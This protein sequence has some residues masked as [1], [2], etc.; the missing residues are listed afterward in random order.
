MQQSLSFAFGTQNVTSTHHQASCLHSC[1]RCILPA[2]FASSQAALPLTEARLKP[3]SETETPCARSGSPARVD[4]IGVSCYSSRDLVTWRNEGAPIAWVGP[5]Y[6]SGALTPV[7]SSMH[8]TTRLLHHG[9]ERLRIHPDKK[10]HTSPALIWL[11]AIAACMRCDPTTAQSHPSGR[12]WIHPCGSCHVGRPCCSRTACLAPCAQ[13]W[14][15]ARGRTQT[16]RRTAWWS[17]QRCG[18]PRVPLIKT[19]KP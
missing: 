6:Q 12:L 2:T 11:C 13:A 18:G 3:Q 15:C 5:R 4:V 9:L 17:G 8:R 14:C 16:W 7:L 10:N 1:V 19:L